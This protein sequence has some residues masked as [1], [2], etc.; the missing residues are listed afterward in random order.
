[1]TKNY[2]EEGLQEVKS[3]CVEVYQSN[4]FFYGPQSFLLICFK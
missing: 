3:T 2:N 1:M 4:M